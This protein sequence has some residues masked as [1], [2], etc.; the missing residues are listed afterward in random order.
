MTGE[1][2][3]IGIAQLAVVIAGFTA[4][5]SALT[6][7]GGAWSPANR[8]RHRAIVST[9]FNVMFESLLP[10]ILFAWLAD[11]R[12]TLMLSSTL[13]TAWTAVVV[14][15]RGRQLVRAGGLSTPSGRLLA[16][17]GPIAVLLF[18]ANALLLASVAVYAL[19]LCVQLTVAVTSFYTLVSSA[20]D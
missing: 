9:S 7:P 3:L 16:A 1:A 18:A 12:S 4:V 11:E 20:S 8:I 2:L 6:P 14:V 17:T 13:V 15:V 5:T 10:V 19:A